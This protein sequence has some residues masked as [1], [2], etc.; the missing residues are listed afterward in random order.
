MRPLAFA[1]TLAVPAIP[2]MVALPAMLTACG[3]AALAPAT[4]EPPRWS[5]EGEGGPAHWAV[6]DPKFAACGQGQKQSP[7]D[8]P[9]HLDRAS[10][11]APAAPTWDPIPLKPLNNGHM[12]VVDDAAPSSFVLDGTTYTLKQFHFHAPAEHTIDGRAYDAEMHLVHKAP[13]GKTVV[14]AL[15]FHHGREND[16]LRP[17]F[18][19]MPMGAHDGAVDTGKTIDL[20]PLLPKTPSYI[21]YEGSLTAPPCTEGITWLV[22]KPDPDA[23]LQMS[24]GQ[25]ARI[26]LATH[27]ATNRP[28]QPANGRV[29]LELA[30]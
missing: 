25:I 21:R 22:V 13:D 7:I 29:V 11:K 5:Y 30:P 24:A 1:L 6:L 9:G 12:V 20:T 27:G 4:A 15:L 19:A 23:P 17:F 10:A 8:L 18:D 3:G 28:L 14:V 26:K 16:L 2:S